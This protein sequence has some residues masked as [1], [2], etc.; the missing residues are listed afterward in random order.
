MV[1]LVLSLFTFSRVTARNFYHGRLET[2]CVC[3]F[4]DGLTV[5]QKSPIA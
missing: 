2:I 5:L 3:K 1:R 4:A